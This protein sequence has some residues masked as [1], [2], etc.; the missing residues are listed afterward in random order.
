MLRSPAQRDVSEALIFRTIEEQ[1]ALVSKAAA[2]A[3]TAK[4]KSGRRGKTM[5]V[6]PL[7]PWQSPPAGPS[8]EV[9]YSKP[10]EPY[11]AEI[12]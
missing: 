2:Q 10:V 11:D 5:K 3:E 8:P 12:W 9:D 6:V 7:P 1:R 4:K